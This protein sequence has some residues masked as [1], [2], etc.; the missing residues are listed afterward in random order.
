MSLVSILVDKVTPGRRGTVFSLKD[1]VKD[2]PISNLTID[3]TLTESHSTEAEVTENPVEQGVVIAD[4]IDLKPE[5]FTLTGVISG[6]PLNLSASIAGAATAAGAF[7]GQSVIGPL[8]A[9]A[10][11]GA[12]AVMG[13]TS[14]PNNRM[15]NSFEALRDLQAKR[16][17]FTVITGL[18]RYTDMVITSLTISRDGK[19]GRSFTFTATLKKVRIVQSK[20]S[21][22]P[23]TFKDVRAAP[24]EDHGKKSAIE[25]TA[26]R[27]TLTKKLTQG[28]FALASKF[29]G[30]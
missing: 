3:A 5:T 28:G 9:L 23:N 7:V 27:R 8:G 1:A 4:H 29:L 6:T 30:G 26:D 18:K 19:S 2:A 14:D 21:K 16:V 11:V 10:G 15:K 25:T 24:A 17:P 22:I 12:G 13:L 20:V